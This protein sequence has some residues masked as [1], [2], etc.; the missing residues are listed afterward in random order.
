MD[1]Q[2]LQTY[3]RGKT[4]KQLLTAVTGDIF[5]M[6]D[7]PVVIRDG[8]V[9]PDQ[10]A[11]QVFTDPAQYNA[12]P[13]MLGGNRDEYKLFMMGDPDLTTTRFGFVPKIRDLALYNRITGY[14]SA[15]W[16]AEAQ[17]EVAALLHQNQGDTVYTYRFDWD[18]EPAYGPVNLHDLWGASHSIE[19]NFVFGD[20][21][22]TGLPLVRS[23]SNGASRD[24][25]SRAMM[26]Y[27]ASFARDGAPGNG[28]DPANP[29]WQPWRETSPSLMVLDSPGHG[30]LHMIDDRERI[31]DIKKQLRTDSAIATPE[32]RCKLYAGLFHAGFGD[33]IYWD[34]A[35]YRSL[36]C[37]NYPP[38]RLPGD[39][40]SDPSTD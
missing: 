10:P 35:E 25:L 3:L 27:W 13:V 23:K 1:D 19:I 33:R 6:Y 37:G 18:D 40:V 22:T 8:Y 21:V 24:A 16:R 2:A 34:A 28:G 12:V 36:G 20:D 29:V 9:V 5:G 26:G 17:G 30:G 4:P 31:A 14:Y 32:A 11:M 15:R 7:W 39:R 38:E